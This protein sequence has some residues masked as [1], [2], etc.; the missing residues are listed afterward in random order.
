MSEKMLHRDLTV[1]NRIKAIET[2]IG[3]ETPQH[4][5]FVD[6]ET[7]KCK[8]DKENVVFKIQM[9]NL[10]LNNEECKDIQVLN[11]DYTNSYE[12]YNRK[13]PLDGFGSCSFSPFGQK[14]NVIG[15]YFCSKNEYKIVRHAVSWPN[16]A[17]IVVK[18]ETRKK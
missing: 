8:I 3:F 17:A 12:D 9:A 6:I 7:F 10:I 18:R 13:L 14:A 4:T 1:N 5:E 15:R 11:I 16:F 2:R